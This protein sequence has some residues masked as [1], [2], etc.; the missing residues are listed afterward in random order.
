M[1]IFYWLKAIPGPHTYMNTSYQCMYMQIRCQHKEVVV[2]T[3]IKTT[4]STTVKYP[5]IST[6]Q[7]QTN[8]IC[9]TYIDSVRY[10]VSGKSLQWKL[11]YSIKSTFFF[12]QS[13]FN[14]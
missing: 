7:N 13:P 6:N 10:N 2:K 12:K 5:L 3:Q 9:S 1:A 14:Y 8:I 4:K 11:R